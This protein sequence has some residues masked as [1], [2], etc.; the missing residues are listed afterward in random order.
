MSNIRRVIAL[1]FLTGYT[2]AMGP[3]CPPLR[4][5][6]RNWTRRPA[7]SPLTAVPPPPSPDRWC[8]CSA[9]WRTGC[10]DAQLLRH[11]EVIVSSFDGMMRMDWQDFIT[12]YLV[13][14][15]NVSMWWPGTT[16][17]SGYMGK[18][19]PQRLKETCEKLG[20][21][22]T[23][24]ARWSRRAS[25]SPPPT[26]APWSPREEMERAV[27]F[28][29]TP[30]AHKPGDPRQE[31]RQLLPGIPHGE[32]AYPLPGDRPRLRRLRHPGSGRRREPHGG[33]QRGCAAHGVR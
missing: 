11:P 3:C 26:S 25:P 24:S 7:P 6:P 30:R 29:V 28:W 2:R 27:D 20:W 18:G 32:S 16:S 10:A 14:Q 21:A 22:A 8:L 33:D 5:G 15:L 17:T 12:E 31:D 9:R 23:S 4:A 13:K 19:N 1:G